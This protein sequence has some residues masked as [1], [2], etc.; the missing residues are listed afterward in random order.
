MKG[1]W[2][3]LEQSSRPEHVTD[4]LPREPWGRA[5]LVYRGNERGFR[6]IDEISWQ[7]TF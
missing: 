7:L 1:I 4:A 2:R 5:R 3:R 6:F